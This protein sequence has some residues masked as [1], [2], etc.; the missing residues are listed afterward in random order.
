[1]TR[2]PY[3]DKRKT[4][5]ERNRCNMALPENVKIGDILKQLDG[6]IEQRL[7]SI[8]SESS[9]FSRDNFKDVKSPFPDSPRNRSAADIFSSRLNQNQLWAEA[10]AAIMRAMKRNL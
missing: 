10:A 8:I 6:L 5:K 4:I 7:R 1:M 3:A 2:Y 9:Y